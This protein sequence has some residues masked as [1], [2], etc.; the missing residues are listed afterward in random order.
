MPMIRYM[1]QRRICEMN[2]SAGAEVG[3]ADDK[4]LFLPMLMDGLRDFS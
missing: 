3:S 1:C 2:E 4:G